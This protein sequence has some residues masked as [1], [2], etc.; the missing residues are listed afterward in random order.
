MPVRGTQSFLKIVG[1]CW[2]RPSLLGLELL[3]RWV[4]G[5]PLAAVLAWQGW[6]IFSAAAPQLAATGVGNAS[7]VYPMQSAVSLANVY[8]ILAPPI[9]HLL[10]WLIPAAVVAWALASGI[11]RSAVLRRYDP[12]LPRRWGALIAL[13]LLRV[14]LYG[15]SIWFWFAAMQ[16]SARV[17]LWG[18]EENVAG[19][20]AL[21]ICISLGIFTLW[22]LASWVS[23]IAPVLALVER[24]DVAS[25]LVRSFRLG[26]LTGKLI[27]INLIMGIIK[28]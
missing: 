26:P 12:S 3:W 17:T 24:R 1:S 27:E 19:Y 23:L 2:R 25:S 18:G 21:V 6:R 9:M 22:A 16:W 4:F 5:I 8:S 13:Q 14:V 28:L 20:C 11:G 10:A 7:L 15:G